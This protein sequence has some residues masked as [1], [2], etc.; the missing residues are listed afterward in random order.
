MTRRVLLAVPLL[1]AACAKPPAAKELH[2]AAAANLSIMFPDLA[3]ACEKATGIRLVPSFGATAQLAQQ[4]ENGGPFDLFLAADAEHVGSLAKEGL[5]AEGSRA[6]YARGRLVIWAP[7][8]PD[9]HSIQDLMRANVKQIGIARP[10]LAPYG[11]ASIEALRTSGLWPGIEKKV[12]Y[13]QNIQAVKQFA[14][15]SNADAAFT[16]LSLVKTSGGHYV[17]IDARLH[18]PIDQ[19]I[20]IVKATKHADLARDAER[21][22]LSSQAAAIYEK[23]GYEIPASQQAG[24]IP[25]TK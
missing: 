11:Q 12:V 2:V 3:R 18:N 8:R 7:R 16:A 22:L 17:E 14:D 21:F 5:I 23:F 13:G 6:V 19:E 9:L 20:C 10:E 24:E 1:L 25:A 4:I 15:S